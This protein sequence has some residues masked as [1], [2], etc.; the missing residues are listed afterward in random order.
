MEKEKNYFSVAYDNEQDILY[1]SF[2]ESAQ[3]AIAQEISDE[4]FLR[5]DPINNNIVNIEILNFRHRIE[6]SI[7]NGTKALKATLNET[8][9]LPH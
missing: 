3:E 8:Y 7:E 6:K 5:F 4:V 1:L 9:L 2:T